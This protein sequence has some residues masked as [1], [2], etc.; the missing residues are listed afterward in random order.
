MPTPTLGRGLFAQ[1]SLFHLL[2]IILLITSFTSTPVLAESNRQPFPQSPSS[3]PFPPRQ[4]ISAPSTDPN[5]SNPPRDNCSFYSTCL[6]SRY[7]CGPEGYPI[8]Y[9]QHY[10]QKFSDERSKLDA[11]GVTWMLD[12]MQCLQ[13]FLV[14]E[15]TAAADAATTCDALE[16]KAFESHSG[17]Y[18][19]NGLCSLGPMDWA[20]IGDIVGVTTLFQSKDAFLATLATGE[21]CLEAYA[22]FLTHLLE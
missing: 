17:C 5:C 10:C 1:I 7:H 15:A 6:E 11:K 12:T 13:R 3:R 9:G 18:V 22:Y 21:D 2:S 20:A 16:M 14:P 8:G 4:L 19:D